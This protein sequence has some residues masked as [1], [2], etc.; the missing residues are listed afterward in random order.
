MSLLFRRI[1]RGFTLIELLV[2]IAIIAILIGL[3]LPAVQKVREAA[4]RMSSTNNLKQIGLA[5][6]AHNTEKGYIPWHGYNAAGNS[7]GYPNINDKNN[8][9]GGWGFQIMPYIDQDQYY[10]AFTAPVGSS[11]PAPSGQYLMP[12]KAFLCPGRGRPG[13]ATQGGTVGPMTDFAINTNVNL[14]TGS[15]GGGSVGTQTNNRKSVASLKKGA[16]NTIL[17]GHK[18]VSVNDYGR[19]SG[20][21]WDEVLLVQNGGSGRSGTVMRQDTNS[22]PNNDWGSPYSSGAYFLF[23]DGSVR[24]ISYAASGSTSFDA[25]LNPLST[26]IVGSF[27]Y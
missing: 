8:Y 21:G 27:N 7:N 22:G 4:S 25:A 15:G 23:G 1:K 19:I 14:S 16:S 17:V 26:N 10:Q 3:L 5:F 2:V 6:H 12:I 13:L 24:L 11:G 20:D 18:Y 9:S